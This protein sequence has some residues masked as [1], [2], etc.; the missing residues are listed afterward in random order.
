MNELYQSYYSLIVI[1]NLLDFTKFLRFLLQD[2]FIAGLK[3]FLIYMNHLF[4]I[5]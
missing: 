4:I 5:I 2:I 1:G 3:G